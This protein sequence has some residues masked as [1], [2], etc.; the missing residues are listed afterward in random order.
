MEEI[1]QFPEYLFAKMGPPNM[2]NGDPTTKT[3]GNSDAPIELTGLRKWISRN[4][5]LLMT[6]S[7]VIVG[8]VSGM[9]TQNCLKIIIF[10]LCALNLVPQVS[11]CVR[12]P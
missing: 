9:Y 11:P 6:L 5:L 3:T 10:H 4:N 2:G 8:I 7:G 1:H 12:I